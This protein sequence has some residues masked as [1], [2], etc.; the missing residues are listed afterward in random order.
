MELAPLSQDREGTPAVEPA[1]NGR[2]VSGRSRG[3]RR[4]GFM[5]ASGQLSGRL[6]AVSRGRR[7]FATDAALAIKIGIICVPLAM[8]PPS[9]AAGAAGE[10]PI[11]KAPGDIGGAMGAQVAFCRER[12]EL[13]GANT[14]LSGEVST[15]RRSEGPGRRPHHP[16][17]WDGT[18]PRPGA[19]H[20]CDPH[21]RLRD[22]AAGGQPTASARWLRRS[23]PAATAGA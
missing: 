13:W 3:R 9:T 16:V 17:V 5:S 21:R 19:G 11:P 20:R 6:R 15:T 23:R 1:G 22:K 14:G 18:D 12:P 2:I 4:A 10:S 7:Q 8:R